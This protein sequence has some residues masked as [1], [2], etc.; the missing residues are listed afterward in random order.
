MNIG[1]TYI[2]GYSKPVTPNP[3]P[4]LHP[5]QL[6]PGW[7]GRRVPLTEVELSTAAGALW[8][9]QPRMAVFTDEVGLSWIL[10][11]VASTLLDPRS[12]TTLVQ[13]TL[14][15]HFKI[16]PCFREGMSRPMYP[17]QY[18]GCRM[19]RLANDP[20]SSLD[21]GAL[22]MHLSELRANSPKLFPSADR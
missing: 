2:R 21:I 13:L 20:L 22:L 5:T 16:R 3:A 10:S 11:G 14:A 18:L 6:V 19:I 12:R 17:V 15:R 7:N 9:Y 4:L 8:S 1:G